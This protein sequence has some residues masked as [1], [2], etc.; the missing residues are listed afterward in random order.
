MLLADQVLSLRQEDA[1]PV[2]EGR[3]IS[4]WEL[5]FAHGPQAL[6]S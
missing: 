4:H 2:R 1:E 6:P 3:S 5:T